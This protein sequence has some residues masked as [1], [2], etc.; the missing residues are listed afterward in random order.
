MTAPL[1]GTR[2]LVTGASG[3]I[4]SH[5]LRLLGPEADVIALSRSPQVSRYG[6][7][8]LRC[9]LSE[10]GAIAGLLDSERPEVVIH[11][12]G[13][14]RG[15]RSLAAVTPTLRT[16]LVSTVELL[17][18]ATRIDSRRIVLSGSLLEEPA[19]ADAKTI[20]P[21]P[22][23]AS[24]WAGS[25][26]GRMFHS[27]FGTPVVILRPSF[28]YGPGQ[29]RSKLIPHVITALLDDDS[30]RLSSGERLLDCVYAEDVARA[31]IAAATAPGV[32]GRTI[33]IGRGVLT[34]VRRIV[35]LIV[36]AVGP[37]AGR[38][39]FGA[40][41]VRPLEQDVRVDVADTARVLGWRATTDLE[42]GLRRTV[43]WFRDDARRR[44]EL[45]LG[46]TDP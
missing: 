33:D 14:V 2:V 18:A 1:A 5:A 43:E 24:R 8:W 4:G 23:G 11:L 25:A 42:M 20:P 32:E 28:A 26:Y 36:E 29:E 38:P 17:E 41:P 13:A 27:L 19:R 9:D 35:Q 37:T 3:L 39:V 44:P 45:T 22:Y 31:Y 12:A 21:S 34:S 30:P 6:E 15:D 40:L 10:S 46:A 7:R 16:N